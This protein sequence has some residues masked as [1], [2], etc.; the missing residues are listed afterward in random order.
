MSVDIREVSV[1][2]IAR[3]PN[4]HALLDEYGEE[5]GLEGM[6]PPAW[7]LDVYLQM[8]EAGFLHPL[9]A[10][11]GGRLLGFLLL[12][13][14]SV[15]H[16]GA[17]IAVSESFFVASADR[18]TGAGMK[19]LKAAEKKAVALEAVG[20]LVSSP[21]HGRLGEVLAKTEYVVSN[22]VYFRSLT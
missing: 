13:V 4:I 10:Y 21:A 15:P 14:H 3:A 6:P 2:E 12:L 1:A 19:L 11:E 18:S 5:S 17:V 16:Y 9:G 8:E 7:Q 22:V 20:L